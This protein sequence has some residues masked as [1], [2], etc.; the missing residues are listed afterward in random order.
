MLVN[1]KTQS[2]E[3]DHPPKSI[4]QRAQSHPTLCDPMGCSPPGSSV[5]GMFQTRTLEWVTFPTLGGLSN[6]RA[7]PKS[8]VSHAPA[9]V[10]LTTVPPGK[11]KAT[12]R[13]TATSIKNSRIILS[14]HRNWYIESE[15]YTEI[16]KIENMATW[17]TRT[18]L[19]PL[20]F[21]MRNFI[22]KLY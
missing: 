14:V 15:V 2:S 13:V 12:S 8:L 3:H 17:R 19:D 9:G 16:Q 6:P 1:E 11:P 5:R 20:K 4:N 10:L 18:K 21:Y 7:E 22:I